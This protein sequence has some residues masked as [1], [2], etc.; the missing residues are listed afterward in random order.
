M[1]AFAIAPFAIAP[2]RHYTNSPLHQFAITPFRHYTN[3]PLHH[4]PMAIVRER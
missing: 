1:Q 3:S 4:S 2:I